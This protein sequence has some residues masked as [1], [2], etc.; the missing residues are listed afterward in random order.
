MLFTVCNMNTGEAM[1]GCTLQKTCHEHAE[2]HLID[3]FIFVLGWHVERI[4]RPSWLFIIIIVYHSHIRR[5]LGLHKG[6]KK[7]Q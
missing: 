1:H 2:R 6:E 7:E 4:E 3:R 5:W